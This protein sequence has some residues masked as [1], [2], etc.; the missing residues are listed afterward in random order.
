LYVAAKPFV[1]IPLLSSL[2]ISVWI[3]FT[4]SWSGCL[5]KASASPFSLPFL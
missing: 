1:R 5:L 3:F 2:R 4:S